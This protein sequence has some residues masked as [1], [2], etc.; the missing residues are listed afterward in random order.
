MIGEGIVTRVPRARRGRPSRA[1]PRRFP[2]RAQIPGIARRRTRG[3]TCGRS[4][5]CAWAGR[6]R[7][8]KP[9]LLLVGGVWEVGPKSSVQLC[10]AG[11]GRETLKSTLES[12]QRDARPCG[13]GIRENQSGSVF[14]SKAGARDLNGN[15]R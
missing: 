13:R 12:A 1:I 8:G 4:A 9:S 14:G 5:G 10:R 2:R 11:R 6:G 7:R 3:R 15:R